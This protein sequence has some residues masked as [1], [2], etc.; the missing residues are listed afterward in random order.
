MFLY[1][2]FENQPKKFG[3]GTWPERTVNLPGHAGTS[4]TLS[5]AKPSAAMDCIRPPTT[6]LK[7][8]EQYCRIV[9]ANPSQFRYFRRLAGV[10]EY[11]RRCPVSLNIPT[12][13]LHFIANRVS[14][15]GDKKRNL[16][17][18]A[19]ISSSSQVSPRKTRYCSARSWSP[20]RSGGI[21]TSS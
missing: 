12:A 2:S 4:R 19:V 20:T 3:I 14:K 15:N 21:V 1:R 6:R 9:V 5:A 18:G 7:P 8:G 11:M 17:A 16:Q 10:A 13:T